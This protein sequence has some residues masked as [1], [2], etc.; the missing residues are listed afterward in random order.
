MVIVCTENRNF[1]CYAEQDKTRLYSF[2]STLQ[3]DMYKR[4]KAY[5]EN[6]QRY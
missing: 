4:G 3:H 5:E 1:K 2:N 6:L